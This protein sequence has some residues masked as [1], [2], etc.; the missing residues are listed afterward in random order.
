SWAEANNAAALKEFAATGTELKTLPSDVVEALRTE[1]TPVYE[2]LAADDP[3]FKK[4]MDNYFA[5]KA[6][7]DVWADASEMVWHSQLRGA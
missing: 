1:M 6:E 2:E 4:V 5:F 3:L 7:H